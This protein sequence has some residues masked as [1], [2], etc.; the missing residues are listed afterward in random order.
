MLVVYPDVSH[1]DNSFCVRSC[2]TQD[3]ILEKANRNEHAGSKI[4]QPV[5][6]KRVETE[7]PKSSRA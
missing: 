4:Q 2:E 3:Q 7:T 5:L 1:S 6:Y